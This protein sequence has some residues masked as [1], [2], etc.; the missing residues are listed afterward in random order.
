MAAI[1]E[2]E[3]ELATV[4]ETIAQCPGVVRRS[5]I[6]LLFSLA[7]KFTVI[8]VENPPSVSL[9]CEQTTRSVKT[10]RT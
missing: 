1:N 5:D 3:C 2:V 10:G 4:S 7:I 8:C 9:A 6:H